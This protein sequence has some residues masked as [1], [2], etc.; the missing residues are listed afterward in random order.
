MG[1]SDDPGLREAILDT[2]LE[3][4]CQ[5]GDQGLTMRGI[6]RK[7]GVSATALYQHFDSKATI[8]Q[9][10]RLRGLK[11]INECLGPAFLLDNPL[12][13]LR[14]QALRYLA[15]ARENPWLYCLLLVEDET[16]WG[17][18]TPEELQ[19]VMR[20][21]LLVRQAILEGME[22]GVLRPDLPVEETATMLWT[23]LHGLALLILRGRISEE[24]PAFPVASTDDLT[25][26]LVES[27]IRGL[28]PD[29]VPDP[30]LDR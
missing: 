1:L 16:A 20:S 30:R 17:M 25:A 22:R 14:D 8:L 18:L 21:T 13:R 23:V 24:H 12:D 7:L 28:A 3:L 2:S 15:F 4:G 19:H 26:M 9:A 11:L 5:F 27:I 10:I 6:A 29:P